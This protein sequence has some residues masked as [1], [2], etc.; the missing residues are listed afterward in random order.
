MTPGQWF[1]N[2]G[3]EVLPFDQV[4]DC[5]PWESITRDEWSDINKNAMTALSIRVVGENIAALCVCPVGI[6]GSLIAAASVWN[7]AFTKRERFYRW[8]FVLTVIDFLFNLSYLSHCLANGTLFPSMR[9]YKYV[10]TQIICRLKGIAVGLSL[11]SDVCTLCMST[12][13]LITL[14]KAEKQGGW[15]LTVVEICVVFAVATI[16]LV[17][18]EAQYAVVAVGN[19]ALGFM[20][21]DYL[22]SEV[23]YSAWWNNLYLAANIV[24]PYVLLFLMIFLYVGIGIVALK[25]RKSKVFHSTSSQHQQEIQKQSSAILKLCLALSILFVCNQLGYILIGI[26]VKMYNNIG[27]TFASSYADLLLL[28]RVYFFTCVSYP[29]RVSLECLSKS[30]NFFIYFLFTRSFR[31]EFRQAWRRALRRPST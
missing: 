23:T 19:D 29:T 2:A 14:R 16:R 11:A 5:W 3:V 4:K 9:S 7:R 22:S 12:E 1:S 24:T 10:D 20:K 6:I 17:V 31:D 26:F 15:L 21:Y 13:R 28:V 25:R 27:L 8:M 18:F 30:I